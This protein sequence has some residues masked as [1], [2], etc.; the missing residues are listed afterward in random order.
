[1]NEQEGQTMKLGIYGGTFNPPHLGHLTSARLALD[2]L[3]LDALQFVPAATPPHKAL[4][5]GSP[6]PE[7]RLAMVELAA[8]GLLMPKRVGVSDMEF[9]RPGKSYTADTLEQLHAQYPGA[10][11]WLLMGTDMFLTL[12]TWRE[13][14]V[15]TRLAGVCT[16]ARTSSDPME[17]LNAQ[18]ERLQEEF[19]AR[20]RVL[21]L[22]QVV[23]VSSTQLREL[24]ARGEGQQYLPPAVYGYIIRRGLYGVHWD[25]KHL[26]DRE[27]RACSYSMIKAKRIAHVQGTEGE[28][29]RLARRWGADEEHARRAAI[30]HDCT[31]YLD[32]EEQLQ[33]CRK[34]G[35]VLDDLEQQAV[36]LLHAK[37]GACVARDVYGV[38][39]DI[40][41]AIFWHTTG[42]ADMSLLEKI[43]YIADYMEPTRDFPGVERLRALAYEDLDAAVCLGC[44]M[45]I[46]EMAERG[47]PVH[48]NTVKARDWL[49]THR[50]GTVD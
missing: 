3:G 29:A 6:A 34:Y 20:T 18:A 22:P 21:Q 11:L 13:P 38:S 33:L 41:N 26:P 19:G 27:L 37:T 43:L 7:E 12:H 32:M 1:M 24:L 47:L 48:P 23:D 2:A 39:G 5:A 40:Y 44:E 25:L 45:S 35:I 42:K 10:E 8:D 36:K 30:L 46:E 31:K 4:P 49:K 50:K 15:I 28:A 9:T 14:E 16:F 17:E